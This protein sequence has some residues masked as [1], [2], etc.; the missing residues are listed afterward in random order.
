M[1]W[2]VWLISGLWLLPCAY[3]Q[4]D[5]KPP[6]PRWSDEDAQRLLQ[7]EEFELDLLFRDLSDSELAAP[8]FSDPTIPRPD[9]SKDEEA[10]PITEEDLVKYF[11]KKPESFLVDPQKVLGMQEYEDCLSFLNYH[12]SDSTVGFYVYLFD[13]KQVIPAE[14]EMETIWRQHYADDGP[15]V[16]LFY[17]MGEPERADIFVSPELMKSV[18]NAE[19]KRA[20]QSA[21]NLASVKSRGEDQLDG[22]CVQMSNRIYWMEKALEAGVIAPPEAE[23]EVKAPSKHKLLW[24]ALVTW[25]HAWMTP[26]LIAFGIVMTAGLFTLWQRAR[27]RYRLPTREIAPRLGGKQGAG[28]G[29]VVSFGNPYQSASAQREKMPDDL[30]LL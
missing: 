7:G 29:A 4:E 14:I 20:L 13:R 25:W 27:R 18:G 11:A 5:E 10:A 28:V 15:A 2:R 3:S 23:P 30:D 6:L 22:F 8:V 19:R 24:A 17:Y 26:I 12:A 21:I 16:L 9:F 1:N